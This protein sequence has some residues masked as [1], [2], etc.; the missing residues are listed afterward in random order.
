MLLA[1]FLQH[2]IVNDFTPLT[3]LGRSLTAALFHVESWYSINNRT[4]HAYNR[5][6]PTLSLEPSA[7]LDTIMN[8][9]RQQVE[10]SLLSQWNLQPLVERHHERG[11]IVTVDRDWMRLIFSTGQ[12][13]FSATVNT[14]SPHNVKDTYEFNTFNAPLCRPYRTSLDYG[15]YWSQMTSIHEY[16]HVHQDMQKLSLCNERDNNTL[17]IDTLVH[18]L[19][20]D[21]MAFTSQHLGYFRNSND[22]LVSMLRSVLLADLET[23]V[24]PVFHNNGLYRMFKTIIKH[25]GPCRDQIK[26][27]LISPL[28]KEVEDALFPEYQLINY[29]DSNVTSASS[30]S[31][32]YLPSFKALHS[33]KRCIIDTG[34][35]VSATSEAHNLTDI[36]PC[37][38][39]TA[40]PAF[41]PPIKPTKRG[42][43]GP[44]Q[45]DT[46]FIDN[47]PDTLLSVS[48]I[49][50]GGKLNSQNIA[51]FT[52][53]SVYIY[54]QDSVKSAL[55]QMSKNGVEILRGYISDGI[56][57]TQPNQ[58]ILSSCAANLYLANFKPASLYDHVHMVTGHPG[59]R[60]MLWHQ[61]NSL[62]AKFT[63][64]DA[65]RQRSTCKGCVYGSLA[66]T[67]TDHH[68]VHRAI[69]QK[70]GQ[71]FTL[72]AYTHT[73]YSSRGHKYCDIYTDIAT[74]RCYPVFTKD[75][76]AQELCEK[77][78]ILFNQHP[79]WKY[80]NDDDPR[81]FIRL[82]SES[83]Y[84][85]L[86]FLAFVA[87]VGYQLE[88]TPVR[89]KHAGGIAER[90]VGVMVS[91][92]NVAMLSANTPVPQK[93]WDFA[94]SYAC[95]THSFNFSRVI[96]TSPYTKITGQPINIKY[97]QPFWAS[98]YVFIPLSKRIK[99]GEPRAY[100]AHFVGYSNT[101]ISFPNYFVIPVLENGQYGKE[102]E[103]K[104]VIFDP[105][106]DFRVYTENE[107]PYDREFANTDHYVPFLHRTK[108]PA[109]LQGPTASPVFPISEDT[110]EPDFP[111][112]SDYL[113]PPIMSTEP[114]ASEETTDENVNHVNDP[115]EDEHGHPIYWYNFTV[116]NAEYAH[117]MCETQHFKKMSP[118][119]DPRVPS[120]FSKAILS[121]L[122]RASIDKECDKFAKNDCLRV[123]P[124]NGQHLVPMMW[125]FTIKTDGTLKARLVGR[126]DLMQPYVDFDPNAVYC[127]NVSSCSIKMCLSIAAKYKHIMRG[128]DL[129]GA[130]LVTRA[131]KDYPVHI[132]TPEGY[133]VPSGFCIQAIGN[134]YGFPPAGQN[135]S[136]EFDKCVM[137]CGYKN[138]P[139]DLKFFYKWIDGRICLLIAH[140]DDFR[141]FG[142]SQD[143]PEWDLLVKTFEQH[144]YKVTD[145]TDKE[146]V[147]I[148]ITIDSDSNYYIDQTR[149]IDDILDGIGMKNCRGENLPYPLGNDSLSK[150]DNASP[151]QLEECAKFPY[152]RI[153][154]QL[155]YGMVHTMMPIMY[156]LNVLSRYGNNP[157]PRHIEF[158]RHLLRY[159][160]TSRADRLKFET[161]D[162]P[163]D[164]I[165]M[166][167]LLQLRFQCDADL[168]G[169]P[170]N[171]HSQTS[172][173]GYLGGSLICWCSTDQGSVSTS[174][175]ESEIKAVN[176]TLKSE[177]IANRGILSEMGWLQAPT[178]IEEDNKACV[179]ASVVR[180]MTRGL[181][182]LAITENFLKEKYADKT[183]VLIKVASGDNNS[184]IGTKRVTKPIFEFLTHKLIDRS[185]RGVPIKTKD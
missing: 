123:V 113:S 128:G 111:L 83:S 122:W 81:R 106:I 150:L 181:R 60:G 180:H 99:L 69:P 140:S 72:D 77:S 23:V 151:A 137:E 97:L 12:T 85:S 185:L 22:D 30:Y 117:I 34:A 94:M 108:A 152:R 71:C 73:F 130:Y 76:S 160:K 75:R 18:V 175:A 57:T 58:T 173:L 36:R 103:S 37:V 65:S 139:W 142:S 158:A 50:N 164:L 153:V 68:R 110:F 102:R 53:D 163:Y 33:V 2:N 107:E 56:Y 4:L 31:F 177:V 169:N 119:R 88:R 27:C 144:N 131:N 92:T 80:R 157:G 51:V 95:E 115:Y 184:D 78:L 19:I 10:V 178:I 179:D 87:S 91:K 114:I 93:F 44:L 42:L 14:N 159:V 49:C 13:L 116:R 135:F 28:T 66:Q 148:N 15:H 7:W 121:P 52:T 154:G 90:A 16:V 171:Y 62:N 84:R 21:F 172:Y 48:Q 67:G 136:I 5:R 47:M 124:F 149:M 141:W 127:G 39:M 40:Y 24:C 129:E 125:L 1:P 45:L 134:L 32:T 96:G 174:T 70:P 120:S 168:A 98:C 79:E 165:T 133:T 86:E 74:R 38:N 147:G 170:D 8:P 63:T 55:N 41:G 132:R 155:M 105:T 100:K 89:D 182:H 64:P 138:T 61:K 161:H 145:A 35:S 3:L 183:C 156:A 82:D 176:H 20:Y 109:I 43:Y 17:F 6:D 26:R 29:P 126:G 59:V 101:T 167:N 146:F 25:S 9:A 162:G 11:D 112:R 143:L 118:I 54:N 46:L 104:D 166:T